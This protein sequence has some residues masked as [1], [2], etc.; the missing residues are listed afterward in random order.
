MMTYIQFV[1]RVAEWGDNQS[2]QAIMAYWTMISMD[3]EDGSLDT[4]QPVFTPMALK[5][6]RKGNN[7]N[8]P[9]WEEAMTGPHRDK[10]E[11]AM[12]KEIRELEAKGTWTGV[13]RKSVPE[14]ANIVPLTWVLTIKKLPNGD[15][16]KFK[17][18]ICVR[19]DLQRLRS[20]EVYS[21]VCKWTTIRSVL[22]FAIKHG[23][24]TRQIDF[25]NAFVQS[26][27]K[28]E[29]K[30]FVRLPRGFGY[31]EDAVLQLNKSLCGMRDSPLYWFNTLKSAVVKELGFEQSKEDQCLFFHPKL[32]A[33]LLVYVDDC[34]LFAH[35]DSTIDDIIAKLRKFHE[36][37]EQEMA[38]D[39]YGYLGIEINLSGETVEL[40]QTGLTDKILKA[41][42]MENANSC[43]TP[44]KEDFLV[45]DLDG[46]P[47]DEEWEYASVLGM[48]MHLTHTRPDTQ[49]A[50]HQCAKFAH[51]PRQC[52]ANAIKKICRYLCGARKRGIR[53]QRKILNSDV[54]HVNCFV[55]ASFAPVWDQFDDE[56]NARSQTGYAVRIDDVPVT[57][58]SR[59]QQLTAMS[60][61]EAELIA[62]SAAMREL[63]W[64]R[65]LTADISRGLGIACDKKT[66]IRSTVFEDNEGAIHLAKRPDLTPRARHLSVKYHQFKENLGADKDGDGISI[67]WVPTNL[68]IA[69]V[70]TKGVGPLKFKPLRDLLMGWADGAPDLL[71]HGVRKGELKDSHSTNGGRPDLEPPDG[72]DSGT[73]KTPNG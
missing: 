46:D 28:P 2:T 61:T 68:Q 42:K 41:V 49:F 20:D 62:M 29:D 37:D 70:F 66:I 54:L 9:T 63:L 57:W 11:K 3:P 50:V 13:L 21:P 64:V 58:C 59:K 47:F 8:A 72:S 17:A 31:T 5:A 35:D 27:L 16:D 69:D 55:D 40:L 52:H 24:K 1:Q 14:G 67:Q 56:D 32:K 51:N 30:V 6:T 34:L 19:G 23:L 10:F 71:N 33:I 73:S 44:A 18:R 65:R 4:F 60:S 48:L 36:L 25:A 45:K 15:F 26:T 53:F 12:L 7:P 38:R 43:E 39:V 22:A